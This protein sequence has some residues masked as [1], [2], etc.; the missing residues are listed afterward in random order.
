MALPE[1]SGTLQHGKK[2]VSGSEGPQDSTMRTGDVRE[3]MSPRS[4]YRNS[5]TNYRIPSRVGC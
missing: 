1:D 2:N 5:N 3:Q 4:I